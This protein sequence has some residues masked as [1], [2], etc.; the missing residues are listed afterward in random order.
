M[1]TGEISTSKAVK[2]CNHALAKIM[3]KNNCLPRYQQGNVGICQWLNI[4]VYYK[5]IHMASRLAIRIIANTLTSITL[6]LISNS[7]PVFED[8]TADK[9]FEDQT[10]DKNLFLAAC[11]QADC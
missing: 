8:Q 5:H 10:A 11:T 2:S 7:M 3:I 6:A 4:H 9:N 1:A